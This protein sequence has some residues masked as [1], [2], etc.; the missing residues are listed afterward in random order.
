MSL[1]KLLSNYAGYNLWANTT[2]AE[3]LKLKPIA[4]LEK[5]V[6]SSY[7]C[8]AKT[9]QHLLETEKFWHSVLQATPEQQPARWQ[10]VDCTNEEV[11]FEMVKQS[12]NLSAYVIALS[13]E[14]LL[15][16][17][18]LDTSWMKGQQPRFE[19]IQHCIN[20]STYHRGQVITISRNIGLT[21]PPNT[22]YN[23]YNMV[24]RMLV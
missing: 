9:I 23:Y 3:W 11:V 24:V 22:D 12:E 7:P 2:I 15:A 13:E 8:I 4:F 19:F 5:E 16:P 1:Q 20:H 6:P 21:D 14:Q 10:K 18:Q 17:C